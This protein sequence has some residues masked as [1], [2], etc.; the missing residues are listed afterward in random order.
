MDTYFLLQAAVF[1]NEESKILTAYQFCRGGT[2][3][4][5]AKYHTKQYIK[6][7]SGEVYDREAVE[8]TWNGIKRQMKKHFGD[9]YKKETA[10]AKL[11][12]ISQGTHRVRQYIEDFKQ[13]LPDADLPEDQ[14]VQ[15]LLGGVN[16]HLWKIIEYKEFN[17][18]DF[19]E[20]C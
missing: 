6:A 14:Q 16:E 8:F 2:A 7:L 5:W 18:N 19:E 10:R 20:L 4:Q 17:R 1:I 11:A 3:G 9:H 12:R 15:Y 13:L